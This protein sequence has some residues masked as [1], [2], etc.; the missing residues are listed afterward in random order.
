MEVSGV[1]AAAAQVESS[2]G[3]MRKAL[4]VASNQSA[5]LLRSLDPALGQN[6]DVQA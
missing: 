4:D 1:Q 2:M 5:A 3:L 6:L